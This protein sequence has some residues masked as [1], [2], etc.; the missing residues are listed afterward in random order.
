VTVSGLIM[1]RVLKSALPKWLG[2]QRDF[3]DWESGFC[4]SDSIELMGIGTALG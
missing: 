4:A 3:Y 2:R 1:A